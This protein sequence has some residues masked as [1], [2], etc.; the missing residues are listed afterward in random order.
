MTP[1]VGMN[2]IKGPLQVFTSVNLIVGRQVRE[3]VNPR[4]DEIRWLVNQYFPDFWLYIGIFSQVVSTS[5]L[6][7]L[8]CNSNCLPSL[9]F[10]CRMIK[11]YIAEPEKQKFMA[12]VFLCMSALELMKQQFDL[13]SFYVSCCSS[14]SI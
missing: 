3:A 4:P 11:H 12:R 2:G 5:S 13:R 1:V 9:L 10:L 14:S 8:S 7:S 6:S